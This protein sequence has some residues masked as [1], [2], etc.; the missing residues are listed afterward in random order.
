MTLYIRLII[1]P[2]AVACILIIV[3]ACTGIRQSEVSRA[4]LSST[5][6]N[7]W[8]TTGDKSKLLK[9]EIGPNFTYAAL[10]NAA[11]IDVDPTIRYQTMVGFGASITDSSA[12]LLQNK[13]NAQQRHELMKELFGRETNGVGFDFVRLTIGASDFS[14]RHYSLND[15]PKGETDFELKSFNLNSMQPDVIPT[16]REALAINSGLHVMA[17]P[18]SAPAWMK[19]TGNLIKGTLKPEAYEV[20]SKYLIRYVD[21]MNKEGVPISSLTLQNEPH[22]EP[23]DYPGMRLDPKQRIKIVSDHLGPALVRRKG[24]MELVD[25]D[26]NWDEP[27]SPMTVLADS[28][29][30]PYITGIGWHCYAGHVQIQASLHDSFPDKD[31]W[32]T[33]CSGG[34]WKPHWH[35]TFPWMVKH[36]VIGST[37]GWAKGVL[38][39][40]LALDENHGPHLGGCKDCRGVVTINSKTG[41]I[42]RNLEYYAL[43]HASKFVR[44]G[45]KRIASTAAI[46]GLESVAFQNADDNSVVLIVCNSSSQIANF[47][48]RQSKA[49]FNYSLPSESV[50][51][52]TWANEKH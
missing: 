43:A 28:K 37:R 35:E 47:S 18:W 14:L 17:S 8:L 36:I 4:G 49:A 1:K 51:T 19:S 23:E 11:V 9:H 7:A 26:H 10:K 30:N 27:Q 50:V 34:E 29:A 39:W 13:L 15:I 21:E 42:T 46:D 32:F 44:P 12:W 45:A 31:T 25:W 3:S 5:R 16:M 24:R 6:V 22:F 48:V 40:N 38:M 52:F 41:E 2:L 33:E 20:F